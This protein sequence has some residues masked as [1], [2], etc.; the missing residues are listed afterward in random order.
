MKPSR[1][2]EVR[3]AKYAARN[4][5]T[6]RLDTSSLNDLIDE[7]GDAIEAAARPAAQAAAQVLYDAVQRNVASI[8]RSSGNLA[9]A[10]YQAY[11]ADNSAPGKATYHVSW[12]ATKAPHGQLLENGYIQRYATYLG[13]DGNWYTAVRPEHHGKKAPWIGTGKKG[14]NRKA[15][16]AEKDAWYVPRPGGPV[17]WVAKSFV[18]RAASAFPQALRAAENELLKRIAKG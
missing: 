8:G 10:I 7:I 5:V 3:R 15:T 2:P 17:Q 12:N 18:R 9:R 16:K 13:K 14:R 6:F 11:S 4:S 1:R